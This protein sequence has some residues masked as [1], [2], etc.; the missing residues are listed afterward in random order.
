MV[1]MEV[2]HGDDPAACPFQAQFPNQ[3]DPAFVFLRKNFRIGIFL[4]KMPEK[5]DIARK[6]G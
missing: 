4:K 2:L 6:T 3:A 5:F 1:C